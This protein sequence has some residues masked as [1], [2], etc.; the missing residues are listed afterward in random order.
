MRISDIKHLD[1]LREKRFKEIFS[2]RLRISV[3]MGTCGMGNGAEEVYKALEKEIRR[4]KSGILLGKVGCFGFCAGEPLVNV[5]LPGKP[6]IILHKVAPKDAAK[7]VEKALKG[8]IYREKVL[9]KIEEW[10][11]ITGKATYG[12]GFPGIPKWDEVP[13]FKGQ[14]KIVLRD[15]GLIDPEN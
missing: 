13:F 12:R 7:I 1:I 8:D 10:D 4:K 14:K 11:H 3:G 15:F 9:C 5:Y 2:G 6:L